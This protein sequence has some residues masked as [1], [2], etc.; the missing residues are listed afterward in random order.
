MLDA[1]ITS[2]DEI[3]SDISKIEDAV[4]EALSKVGQVI[5]GGHRWRV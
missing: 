1:E 3:S 4:T 5:L 2:V